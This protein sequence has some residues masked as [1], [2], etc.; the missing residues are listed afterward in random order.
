MELLLE[1]DDCDLAQDPGAQWVVSARR[2]QANAEIEPP[3]DAS[4]AAHCCVARA[5]QASFDK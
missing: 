1:L 4:R 5:P 2:R 3:K